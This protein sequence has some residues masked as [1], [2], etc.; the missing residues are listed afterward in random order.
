[1]KVI[2]RLRS[3]VFPDFASSAIEMYARVVETQRP[4]R[5]DLYEPATHR[6]WAPHA[7][8]RGGDLFATL[9]I[10]ITARKSGDARQRYLLELSDRLR[11]LR[12]AEEILVTATAVLAEHLEAQR[13]YY[14]EYFLDEGFATIRGEHIRTDAPTLKGR[15]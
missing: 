2:G 9:Y 5:I 15:N 7:V 12:E 6:G 4:E 3:E 14:V 13:A 11:P 1:S 8:P 10:D